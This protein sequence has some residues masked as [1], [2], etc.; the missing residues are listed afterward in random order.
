MVYLMRIS[1]SRLSD[2]LLQHPC[3]VVG[4]FAMGVEQHGDISDV[5]EVVCWHFVGDY[6]VE[7]AC[8]ELL[9]GLLED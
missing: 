9:E 7:S 4:W 3:I 2:S 1:L 6:V 8:L 5:F